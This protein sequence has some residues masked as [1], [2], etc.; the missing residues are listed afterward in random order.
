MARLIFPERSP[1]PGHNIKML[2]LTVCVSAKSLFSLIKKQNVIQVT[3]FN[4]CLFINRLCFLK[5]MQNVIVSLFL[6]Y[7]QK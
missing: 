1:S 4:N 7:G 6:I 5:Y 3:F 2:I